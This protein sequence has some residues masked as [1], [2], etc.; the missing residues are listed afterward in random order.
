MVSKADTLIGELKAL[1]IP[2]LVV[3]GE[4]NKGIWTSE[5]K[6][7]AL[8]SLVYISGAGHMMMVENPDAFYGE[9]AK[10]IKGLK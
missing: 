9:V 10:F 5:K 8:F 3:H 7:A 6:M 2:T 1:K 4:K